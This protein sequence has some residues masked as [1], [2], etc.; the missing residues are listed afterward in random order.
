MRVVATHG[1]GS[2]SATWEHQRPVLEV[3][4]HDV[5]TW[6]LR[7]HGDNRGP[8]DSYTR[9]DALADLSSLV[10]ERP[11][12]LLG[13]SL[14]GYLSLALAITRPDVVRGLALVATGPG[15]RD[16]AAREQWNEYISTATGAGPEVGIGLQPDALVIDGLRSIGV[17]VLL[18]VG[19]R[20]TRYHAGM[21]YMAKVF[22][23]EVVIIPGA[24]HH[25]HRSHADEINPR[26]VEFIAGI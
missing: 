15:F 9:D 21:A 1:V 7:G 8:Y 18:V 10:G 25:V 26:L 4:G 17:P 16:P 23:T 2:S 12:V 22:D 5:A 14:G 13:H 3:A 24:G 11:S 6:D 20:D 19:E